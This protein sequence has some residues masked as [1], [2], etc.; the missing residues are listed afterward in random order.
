VLKRSMSVNVETLSGS[1]ADKSV[2][3][4]TY[5]PQTPMLL[6]PP[7]TPLVLMCL[8]GSQFVIKVA[9]F[10]STKRIPI[11]Y[12]YVSPSDLA[13][14][15]QVPVLRWGDQMIADS[16]LILD[17]LDTKVPANYAYP[18][19]EARALDAHLGG[20]VNALIQYMNM[21]DA[22][23]FDLSYAREVRKRVPGVLRYVLPCKFSARAI[24]R[25]MGTDAKYRR[26]IDRHWGE[27][28][29]D[30]KAASLL[31]GELQK[32]EDMLG[33]GGAE[34]LWLLNTPAPTAPDFT[35]FG[36]LEH[37]VGDS[38][39]DLGACYPDLFEGGAYPLLKSFF[40]RCKG[41]FGITFTND[42]RVPKG[43][44]FLPSIEEQLRMRP[45]EG[46]A[47]HMAVE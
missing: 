44:N 14:P 9:A 39:I 5:E 27:G 46:E 37:L 20:A 29:D 10:C 35:L 3:G 38:G 25:S 32:L 11:Q 47:G 41:Q 26:N 6:E 7:P 21:F 13:P 1:D 15:S 45:A 31:K 16:G 40:W 34:Q 24:L 8:P 42:Q 4:R 43:S 22:R 2:P 28:V 17:F 36:L 33:S 12:Q 23:G 18:D 19:E 30:E